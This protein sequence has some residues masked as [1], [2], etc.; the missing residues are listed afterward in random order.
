MRLLW[1]AALSLIVLQSLSVEAQGPP[2][3]T[4]QLAAVQVT[5]AKRY[6]QADV[7]RVSGLGSGQSVS[8][9]EITAAAARLGTSGLFKSVKYSYVTNASRI[10]VIFEIEEA[11]WTV[12]V[13]FDNIVWFTDD[14]IT[15]AVRIDVPTFDGTLPPAEGVPD[16]VMRS[17]QKLLESKRIPGRAA[18]Q[19]QTDLTTKKLSYLF[20]VQEP[21]PV[22]CRL[23]FSGVSS[24]LERELTAVSKSALGQDYSRFYLTSMS[25]GTLM[26]VYHRRGYWRARFGSPMPAI[27][28]AGCTGVS[29]TLSVS[30]GVVYSFDNA[31]WTGNG[32]F[33]STELDGMLAM[34]SGEVADSSKIDNGLRRI[35]SAYG[36]KGYLTESSSASPRLDDQSKRALFDVK[37]EE[38][39]QFFMGT[40]AFEGLSTA[41]ANKL[42][43]MW[44]LASGAAYDNSYAADFI[45]KEI[46]PLVPRGTKPPAA[47]ESGD[48]E[49]HVVN[50]TIVF[51]R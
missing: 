21:A 51:E 12:P 38:G 3:S 11:E 33:T 44:K 32:V 45:F 20:K 23:V 8:V 31:Q 14:E 39:P 6:T 47:R 7:A 22:L 34:K 49:K 25:A 24:E 9:A 18:F 43:K 37:V 13:T 41:D 28:S 27:D 1:Y 17:I 36:K 5:G 30:E 50:V 48:S 29:A 16:L 19:P 26:D 2:P 46:M 42:T 40:L 15:Q 4:Y 35:R 10:T